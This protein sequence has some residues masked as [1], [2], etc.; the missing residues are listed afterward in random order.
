MEYVLK[1]TEPEMSLFFIHTLRIIVPVQIILISNQIFIF[2]SAW[3]WYK[4]YFQNTKKHSRL[5][6]IHDLVD[7]KKEK[8]YYTG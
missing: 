8:V 5:N 6:A 2:Q 3:P 1:S 7:H 4:K